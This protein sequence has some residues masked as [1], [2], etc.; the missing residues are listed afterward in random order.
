M[1]VQTTISSVTYD[2][3]ASASTPYPIPFPYLSADDIYVTVQAAGEESVMLLGADDYQVT[4]AGVVT[5]T[6]YPETTEIFIFR[7][8]A[9]LQPTVY[10]NQGK[11]P[12]ATHEQ[13]LDRLTM[14]IQQLT[15]QVIELNGGAGSVIIPSHAAV[16][17]DVL[18]WDDAAERALAQPNRAGQLGWEISTSS[19]W[20]SGSSTLGD[21]YP[22]DPIYS[23]DDHLDLCFVADTGDPGSEQTAL[24]ALLTNW[25]CDAY[26]FGG[27]NSYNG[28]AEIDNDWA[29]FDAFITAEKVFPALGNHD[30]DGANTY[31]PHVAKFS[32][33]PGNRRYYN[34][35]LGNGLVELFVLHSGYN[36]AGTLVEPD[37]NAV[38][39]TQ[40][41]WF[42]AA[43]AAS[44]ARWKIVMFHHPYV[45]SSDEPTDP[46][47]A[48]NW[49]F[50]EMGVH[51]VLNGHAH[52]NEVLTRKGMTIINNGGTVRLD[53]DTGLAPIGTTLGTRIDWVNDTEACA[54]RIFATKDSLNF[55]IWSATNGADSTIRYA[56][57]A[58]ERPANLDEWSR[59]AYAPD[60]QVLNSVR[61][62]VG[63]MSR[64]ML[65]DRGVRISVEDI[66]AGS[67]PTPTAIKLWAG[68][69][70]LVTSV[71]ISGGLSTFVAAELESI[72]EGTAIDVEIL[73]SPDTYSDPVL[74][75]EVAIL[76]RYVQ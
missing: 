8:M 18:N 4:E 32:Y 69:E 58:I 39:S 16:L 20:Y 55:E 6:A 41:D 73:S 62:R 33:L 26:L 70:V 14:L 63:A 65:I 59:E 7:D 72:A 66:G 3:N 28:E 74:G 64:S 36:T 52:L 35:V 19:L 24:A 47:T 40:Y 57:S 75:L 37:G 61:R 67:T 53:G 54:T 9:A 31:A 50:E 48:L 49:G 27:D 51:L 13:A 22:V 42:V 71:V 25:A 68:S 46:K 21:W 2:G 43:L 1:A 45:T 30:I 44:T 12:A 60:E 10:E 17:A 38:D 11:F 29:A 15:R 76:G 5:D 34:K 23:A 56:G